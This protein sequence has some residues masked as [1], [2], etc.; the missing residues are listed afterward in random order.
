[1][2]AAPAIDGYCVLGVD[3]EYDLTAP[4]LLEAMDRAGVA[5]AV[6]ADGGRCALLV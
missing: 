5:A 4:A 2:N 1:M 6:R 3:R